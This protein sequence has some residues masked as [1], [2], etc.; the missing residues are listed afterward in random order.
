MKTFVA[1]NGIVAIPL[2]APIVLFHGSNGMGKTSVLSAL[3]L[4][5][6]G[7]IEHLQRVDSLY[8]AHLLHR[9]ASKGSIKLA[10]AGASKTLSFGGTIQI[11]KDGKTGKN[12]L[13]LSEAKFFSE[14]CYLPQSALGRLL[15]LYQNPDT[16]EKTSPLTKFVKDLLGLD[17]LDAIVDG[18][19]PALNVARIRNLIPEYR[20]LEALNSSIAEEIENYRSREGELSSHIA[21]DRTQ[22]AGSLKLLYGPDSAVHQMLSRPTELAKTVERDSK[23]DRQIIQLTRVRQELASL[24]QRQAN[25]PKTLVAKERQAKELAHKTARDDYQNWLNTA[26]KQLAIIVKN[27]SDLF[28]NLPPVAGSDPIAVREAVESVVRAEKERCDALL[29]KSA[30]ATERVKSLNK[31][32]QRSKARLAEIDTELSN[33]AGDADDLA[34]AL[35]SIV[36]HIHNEICPVCSRDFS[37][38]KKRSLSTHVASS[39]AALTCQAGKLKDYTTEKTQE[40]GRVKTAEQELLAAKKGELSPKTVSDLTVR[41]ARLDET[42]QKLASATNAIAKGSALLKRQSATREE[43][44]QATVG[45]EVSIEIRQEVGKWAEFSAPNQLISSVPWVIQSPFCQQR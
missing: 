12:L 10:Q 27:I 34:H 33:L 21:A 38:T 32:I 2:D 18:L 31:A 45:D 25:I 5:L 19:H 1:L 16:K 40:A 3:E 23:E 11:N 14:R 24:N 9:G 44:A 37:E 42:L 29:K 20:R 22:L 26:G 28:P 43:L 6:T 36:S 8:A 4:A 7:Q 30:A 17:Q 35:A 41:K 15:E 13:A 39:I